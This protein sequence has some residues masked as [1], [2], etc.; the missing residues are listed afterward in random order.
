MS[1]LI[2]QLLF[3]FLMHAE[4]GLEKLFADFAWRP[5]PPTV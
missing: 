2:L 1:S 5:K 3:F 4:G